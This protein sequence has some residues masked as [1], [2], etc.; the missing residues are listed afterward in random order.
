MSIDSLNKKRNKQFR[1]IF[2][3]SAI[4]FIVFLLF[5]SIFS[6]ATSYTPAKPV[7]I[8]SGDTDT[9]YEFLAYTTDASSYW[10]FD[11]G[12]GTYSDWIKWGDFDNYV[13]QEHSWSSPGVYEVRVMHK[14]IYSDTSP[15]SPAL[16][17]SIDISTDLDGDGYSN[18]M[19]EAYGTDGEDPS[20]YPD[21]TDGD[22]IPDSDSP[23]GSYTGDL[24]D[25]NDGLADEKEE[26]F[27]S[28]S[29]DESDV[30][31][32]TI[33]GIAHYFVDT[34]KD[35]KLDIFYNSEKEIHTKSTTE[36]GK[37]LIDF[38]GDNEIEYSYD[39]VNGIASYEKPFEIP[40]MYVILA[41]VLIILFV[42]FILF[43]TGFISVYE[44][45]YIVEE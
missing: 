1:N 16:S 19:E 12:D 22:L 23:A 27:G 39:S 26:L 28:D 6:I 29:K 45:E 8:G 43:K 24:D 2:S 38:D 20:V 30:T 11:W 44:E 13:A 18:D 36:N 7:G 42:I 5:F 14:N 37:I 35:G 21:D 25:D 9:N 34:N 3:V 17:V 4:L 33:S 32:L 10:M 31:S 41:I 15:W 40:W